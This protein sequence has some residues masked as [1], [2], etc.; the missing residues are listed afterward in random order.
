[1]CEIAY[2]HICLQMLD[3][4]TTGILINNIVFRKP[5]VLYRSDASEFGIGGYNLISG[6]AWR[7]ELPVNLRLRSSLNSL[8]FFGMVMR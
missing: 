8:E 3:D 7:F 4:A 5:N 1:M 2:L 6:S